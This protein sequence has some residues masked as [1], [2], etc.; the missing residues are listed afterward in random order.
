MGRIN[1]LPFRIGKMVCKMDFIVVD[2]D[3][4]DVLSLDWIFSL[5]LEWLLTLNANSSKYTMV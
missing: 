4:Y 3:G 5:K 1:D 2:I